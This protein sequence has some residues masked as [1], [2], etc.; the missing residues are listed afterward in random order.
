[1]SA[2]E[3]LNWNSEIGLRFLNLSDVAVNVAVQRLKF[4]VLDLPINLSQL[5]QPEDA[6]E[7]EQFILRAI[8][9]Y[10]L[11]LKAT[12]VTEDQIADL[13]AIT[14]PQTI[15]ESF[16]NLRLSDKRNTLPDFG[17]AIS[18]LRQLK[19]KG[20][21]SFYNF[22]DP[23][24]ELS[25]GAGMAE[26]YWLDDITPESVWY[27]LHNLKTLTWNL[28]YSEDVRIDDLLRVGHFYAASRESANVFL[29]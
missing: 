25:Y 3:E 14:T 21:A 2:K 5:V 13:L 1:M 19:N 9:G 11:A 6:H 4:I 24:D 29:Y 17:H 22:P 15:P 28:L 16:G 23:S 12:D 7:V 8:D 10:T 26:T 18:T 20:K 27:T